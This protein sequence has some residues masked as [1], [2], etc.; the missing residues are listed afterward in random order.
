MLKLYVLYTII[1]KRNKEIRNKR[2]Y[3]VRPIFSEERRLKQGTSNNLVREM[4]FVDEEKY[5]N[6][7][8]IP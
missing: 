2:H 8:R 3:W 6:Y 4:E 7:F 1:K 5:F